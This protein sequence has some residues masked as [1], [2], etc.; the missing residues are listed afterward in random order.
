MIWR[1]IFWRDTVWKFANFS[2]TIYCKNSVKSSFSLKSYTLNQFDEKI[3]QWGKTSEITTLC[4]VKISKF[5]SHD[6]LQKFRQ[7]NFFTKELYCKSFFDEKFLP[8]GKTSEITTL[9]SQFV[10]L[11]QWFFFF[12]FFSLHCQFQCFFSAHPFLFLCY[13]PISGIFF[14]KAKCGNWKLKNLLRNDMTKC[15][16]WK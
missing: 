6:F 15:F 13:I 4:T 1:N 5:F 11:I 10:S 14:T 7:I 2:P 12:L 9:C 16:W 3:L 8:W